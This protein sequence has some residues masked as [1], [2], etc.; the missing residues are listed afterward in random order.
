MPRHLHVSAWTAQPRFGAAT[1]SVLNFQS[2]R[3]AV[4]ETAS[5]RLRPGIEQFPVIVFSIPC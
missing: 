4:T 3:T 5:G 1:L 2:S